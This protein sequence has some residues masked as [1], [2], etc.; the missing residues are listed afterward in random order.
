MMKNTQGQQNSSR[1][2]IV[3]IVG[4]VDHG[5]TALLDY[6]RKSNVV[7]GEAG[8][9]TQSIGG[10]EVEH[11]KQKLTFIDT[12]GHEAFTQ[13]RTQGAHIA[14][15]AILIVSAEEG[16]KPQT[17]EAILTLKETKTP[18]VV[19][20]T[21]IDKPTAQV[22]KVKNELM[23][24]EVYL[25]GMGGDISWQ[26]ISSITGE[27]VNELLDL[28]LLMAEMLD[29]KFD[30]SHAAEGF[31]LE[32]R[33][34]SFKGVM[35]N[36]IIKNG[37]LHQGDEIRTKSASGRVKSLE[38]FLGKRE[39]ELTPSAPATIMGFE[40]L[41][42]TGEAFIAGDIKLL[43]E[44]VGDCFG[45]EVMIRPQVSMMQTAPKIEGQVNVILKSDTAGSLEA[46]RQLV[47][48]TC[49]VL[50][51]GI[52]EITDGDAR[53]AVNTGS[54]ILGF[55]V[56]TTKSATEQARIHGIKIFT[57][58][59]IYR[60]IEALEKHTK[61]KNGP[62]YTGTLEVLRVFGKKDGR[63]ITGG[64]VTKG[65]IK[66]GPIVI[67]RGTDKLG[68]GE[69]VNLQQQKVDAMEVLEGLECG[70]LVETEVEIKEG[71]F[72]MIPDGK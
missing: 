6:L 5:K 36:V 46:L 12:P 32:T 27:G 21:K 68:E 62:Q 10:Y 45:G 58:D 20:I 13:M 14:D 33:K 42:Q 54:I 59:I 31:I 69:I 30:P 18:F 71:D 56:K 57:A 8:G 28:V 70:M 52:G 65:S 11:N 41:P 43:E 19:A 48:G 47:S 51:Q 4:H 16:I 64:K 17:K 37:T 50:E 22:E 40:Q 24:N 49:T 63:T 9:I 61:E 67:F 34:D 55:N 72:L 66:K 1:P 44:S 60:L 15:I 2:P 29:L 3:V 26:G 53:Q 38:N 23:N 25:E 35:V 7:A 39:K